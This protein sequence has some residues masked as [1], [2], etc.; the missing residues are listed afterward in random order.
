MLKPL[1]FLA[2]ALAGLA[3]ALEPAEIITHGPRSAPRIA[4]TFDADMTPGMEQ[5]LKTGRSRSYD[6]TRIYQILDQ[7]RTKATF[8]LS[9]MWIET[10][11]QETRNL[12][13]DPLFELENHSYSHP[14]FEQP[15]FGLP[16]IAGPSK[17]EQILKTKS[18]LQSVAGV[19]NRYFRFPGGCAKAADVALVQQAGLKV[20]HWDV[21]GGDG[22]QPDPRVIEQNVLNRVQDGSIIVLHSHGGPK[23]P[24]TAQALAVIIP[25]LKAR[26]FQFVKLSELLD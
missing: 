15:C 2:I 19:G 7:T 9:G 8:F 4:L 16:G 22:G 23:V 5:A 26:G 13:K 18:L 1:W 3:L 10:Y 17:L 11:P 24:A 14:G 6:N 21:V 25:A 20:V 12:A